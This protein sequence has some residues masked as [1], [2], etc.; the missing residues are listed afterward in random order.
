[1]LLLVDYAS[2]AGI[3]EEVV[4][5]VIEL[6]LLNVAFWPVYCFQPRATVD[7]YTIRSESN[8]CA[9]KQS[10]CQR[11]AYTRMVASEVL[12]PYLWW[13][14]WKSRWRSPFQA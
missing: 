2:C 7:G 8:N 3:G 5:D 13:S 9:Y 14:L 6:G 10:E 4:E 11:I 12:V 1:M